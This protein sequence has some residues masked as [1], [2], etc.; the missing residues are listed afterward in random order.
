MFKRLCR[1]KMDKSYADFMALKKKR[2]SGAGAYNYVDEKATL[3]W[4][5]IKEHPLPL[6][7][8]INKKQLDRALKFCKYFIQS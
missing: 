2:D 7:I 6:N 5:L 8:F 4:D 1:E 3:C